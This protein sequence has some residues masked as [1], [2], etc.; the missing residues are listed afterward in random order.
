MLYEVITTGF[1]RSG[2]VVVSGDDDDGCLGQGGPNALDLLKCEDDGRVGGPDLVEQ[3]ASNHD[4]IGSLVDDGAHSQTKCIGD[5][6]FALVDP[7]SVLAMVR[8]KA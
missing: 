5:I 8:S 6:R 7:E 3:I 2:R 4:R 1:R